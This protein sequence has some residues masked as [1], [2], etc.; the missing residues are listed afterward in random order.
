MPLLEHELP[1]LASPDRAVSDDRRVVRLGD[2]LGHG[3][4]MAVHATLRRGSEC[5]TLRFIPA[6]ARRVVDHHDNAGAA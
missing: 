3:R 4:V 2:K 6:P 1:G 5:T